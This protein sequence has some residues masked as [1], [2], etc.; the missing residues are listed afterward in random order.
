[1]PPAGMARARHGTHGHE[2]G[3][4]RRTDGARPRP[5]PRSITP[6]HDHGRTTA[7]S[8]RAAPLLRADAAGLAGAAG[9]RLQLLRRP[10]SGRRSRRWCTTRRRPRD[11]LLDQLHL[12]LARATCRWW[13]RP[14]AAWQA[15]RPRTRARAQRLGAADAR[16][17]RAARS[18]RSRWAARWLEWLRQRDS[19]DDARRCRWPRCARRRPGRWPL[20]WPPC[21]PARR[22][23]RR[24]WR[25]GFGWAENMVQAAMQ[26]RA[27]GPERRPAPA[28]RG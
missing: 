27:A 12:S 8:R 21:T 5:R 6:R 13:R 24:C 7:P 18:R 15:R 11:W 25:F 19:A 20:R 22:C 26:G 4:T 16:K 2:H 10:G 28:R 14:F 1:M 23:A 3:A 17:R 9:G